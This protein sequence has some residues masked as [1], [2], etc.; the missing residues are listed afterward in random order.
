[1]DKTNTVN[2]TNK[3][4]T[5]LLIAD[6]ISSFGSSMT[7][8]AVTIYI[9]SITQDLLLAAL[10]PLVSLLPRLIITPFVNK[11]HINGSYKALFIVGE[12]LAGITISSMLWLKNIYVMLAV[13]ALYSAIFFVLELYRAEY[14][15]IISTDAKI[16]SRK[17]I[18][19]VVNSFV[20]VVAPIVAGI[21]LQMLGSNLVF[22]IDV[23][24]YIIAAL[25]ILFIDNTKIINCQ[26]ESLETKKKA[27][28]KNLLDKIKL[29]KNS[30]IFIGTLAV[31]FIGGVTSLLT[32][33]YVLHF[34]KSSE[35]I[36]TVLI[37]LLSLG[38]MLGSALV[39]I[40]FF[41]KNSKSISSICLLL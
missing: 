7:N 23:I 34:L 13:F 8:V 31:T 26:P 1:M 10:F 22:I 21:V 16:V 9:F 18:S 3:S 12:I 4:Y 41:Q 6:F 24:S 5:F 35:I 29:T 33:S 27:T 30:N 2:K 38:S 28:F 39:N 32:L 15:K 40:K 11:F 19:Q 25:I 36:Y 14:L 17:S 37:A 20:E